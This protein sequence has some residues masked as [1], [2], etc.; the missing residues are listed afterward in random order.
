MV[1]PEQPLTKTIADIRKTTPVG[2]YSIIDKILDKAEGT[3][4]P[5]AY[6]TDLIHDVNNIKKLVKGYTGNKLTVFWFARDAGT[7]M[8][9]IK[10]D[11]TVEKTNKYSDKNIKSQLE[12]I[13]DMWGYSKAVYKVTN[14][15]ITKENSLTAVLAIIEREMRI[16]NDV[17]IFR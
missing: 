2:K 9:V 3:H 15:R 16:E 14:T 7:Y 4:R 8:I 17:Y 12:L 5:K 1:N 11:Y 13:K 10:P 6:T